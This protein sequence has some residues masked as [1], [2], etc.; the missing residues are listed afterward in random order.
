ME[1]GEGFKKYEPA[2]IGQSQDV[3]HSI[4]SI[5]SNTSNCVWGQ[6][7]TENTRGEH[8]VKQVTV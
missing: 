4:G 6:A 8:S 5:V 2:V 3:K 7:G 1:R